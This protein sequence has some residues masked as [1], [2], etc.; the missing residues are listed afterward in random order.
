MS[1]KEK[2]VKKLRAINILYERFTNH[3]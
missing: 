2:R 1:G 3:N